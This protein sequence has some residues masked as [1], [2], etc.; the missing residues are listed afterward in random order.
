MND[1]AAR[2]CKN[3]AQDAVDSGHEAVGP[4]GDILGRF[5]V[6]TAVTKE[7]PAGPLLHNV[8]QVCLPSQRP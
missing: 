1:M 4:I 5:T 3:V 2:K 6:W 8:A 7:F